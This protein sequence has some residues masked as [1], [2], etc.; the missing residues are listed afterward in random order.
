MVRSS[1][2]PVVVEGGL[3]DHF[4]GTCPAVERDMVTSSGPSPASPTDHRVARH[5][6]GRRRRGGPLRMHAARHGRGVLCVVGSSSASPPHPEPSI[7]RCRAASRRASIREATPTETMEA[8]GLRLHA[9]RSS[10]DLETRRER[11]RTL[12]CRETMR[13]QSPRTN[14]VSASVGS[15]P[16]AATACM[17]P[18]RSQ[19][20]QWV[21]SMRTTTSSNSSMKS[22]ITSWPRAVKYFVR[23]P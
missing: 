20:S 15:M 16:R 1:D 12:G 19:L 5:R 21:G 18:V 6:P 14:Q 17:N 23:M 9:A 2:Q 11:L 8:D 10:P 4:R 13:G 7:W 3:T 22:P